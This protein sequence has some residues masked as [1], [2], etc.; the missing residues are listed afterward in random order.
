MALHI[1]ISGKR[2]ILAAE[3]KCVAEEIEKRIKE[4]LLEEKA[5]AFVGYTSLAIGADSIFA[6]I[7]TRIFKQ[8]LKVILPFPL[9]EY[10]K[11][12]ETQAEND[13]LTGMIQQHPDVVVVTDSIPANAEERNEGYFN[14]GKYIADVC[15]E[16]IFV[17]DEL[18][19]KGK[20]GTADII[21]YLSEKRTGTQVKFI[22]TSPA[23]EDELNNQITKEYEDANKCAIENRNIYK[24]VWR[25]A[26]F[27]GWASVLLFAIDTG[28]FGEEPGSINK[29]L[30]SFEFLCV[31]LTFLLITVAKNRNYHGKYLKYMMRAETFR[32]LKS[33]YHACETVKI[34]SI[35]ITDDTVL[36]RIAENINKGTELNAYQSKW[37]K[38]YAIKSLI[39][40]QIA[41]HEEKIKD[42]GN[43]ASF[44]ETIN[45]LIAIAFLVN[46]ILHF[47][48][49]VFE[50]HSYSH[51]LMIM[52]NI[53]L[54]A[55]Y[56]AVEGVLYF[57]E[58]ALLKKYSTSVSANLK[59]ILEVMPNL[60]EEADNEILISKLSQAVNATGGIMLSDNNI[61]HLILEDKAYYHWVV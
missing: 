4:I 30:V 43:K 26:I 12:F 14:A 11:D 9:D 36:T 29:R 58:W 17:W 24:M 54:P 6:D 45:T 13:F 44:F 18:K 32:M 50:I 59:R 38:S 8:P 60:H 20:G 35:T 40:E 22:K 1:G 23:E 21:G 53:L 31:I 34:S 10:R 55:T 2:N 7:V 61:W 33:F 51:G 15:D 42:I 52:L 39:N 46:I 5:T 16:I 57:Q 37:H 3:K 27:L 48:A 49:V 19:P 25:G 47:L 56:A 41:Y 28:F